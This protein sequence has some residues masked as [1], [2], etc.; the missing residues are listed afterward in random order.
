MVLKAIFSHGMPILWKHHVK[1]LLQS[2]RSISSMISNDKYQSLP[3]ESFAIIP[4]I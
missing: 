4:Y 2:F 1:L 3:M